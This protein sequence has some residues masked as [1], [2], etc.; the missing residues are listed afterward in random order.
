[1]RIVLQIVF[2]ITCA[3]LTVILC[4]VI[5]GAVA[6][7]LHGREY[8]VNSPFV[9]VLTQALPVWL[10]GAGILWIYGFVILGRGWVARTTSKNLILLFVLLFFNTLVSP[11]Y[12]WKRETL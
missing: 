1:M 9:S 3:A 10:G 7:A 2:W 11:I 8:V 4:G 6:G 5:W 12:Y